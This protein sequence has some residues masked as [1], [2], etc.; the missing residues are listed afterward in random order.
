MYD[1]NT[2]AALLLP[3]LYQ[4]GY[5]DPAPRVGILDGR[6]LPVEERWSKAPW[7]GNAAA[8]QA[9]REAPIGATYTT[10]CEVGTAVWVKTDSDRWTL[11]S[12]ARHEEGD[13]GLVH[14]LMHKYLMESRAALAAANAARRELLNVV[15]ALVDVAG[16]AQDQEERGDY[17]MAELIRMARAALA[18]EE[19]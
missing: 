6:M 7:P 17:D 18:R 5:A 12:E 13:E 4:G 14:E 11:Q 10:I 16:P 3:V 19:A 1:T 15:R 9:L 2:T 8:L